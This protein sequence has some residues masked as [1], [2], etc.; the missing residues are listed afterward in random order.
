M[1]V[2]A[3]SWLHPYTRVEGA[4]DWR[5]PGYPVARAQQVQAIACELVKVCGAFNGRSLIH[6]TFAAACTCAKVQIAV[7]WEV[8]QVPEA[9]A[10]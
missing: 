5:P 9:I 6:S 8:P 3:C 4:G 1:S 7:D 2:R 10:V